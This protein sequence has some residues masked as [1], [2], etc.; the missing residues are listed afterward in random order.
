MHLLHSCFISPSSAAPLPLQCSTTPPPLQHHSPSTAAATAGVTAGLLFLLALLL[1]PVVSPHASPLL[2]PLVSL[3]ASLLLPLLLPLLVPLIAFPSATTA[4]ETI[5]HCG[6]LFCSHCCCHRWCHC[7][8]CLLLAIPSL[9]STSSS[10]QEAVTACSLLVSI[11]QP[12]L[13]AFSAPCLLHSMPS[14]LCAFSP[15]CLLSSVPSPLHA[16]SPPC[17]LSSVPSPLHAFSP[18]FLLLSV[19][20]LLH[21]ASSVGG[22]HSCVVLCSSAPLAFPPPCLF[23]RALFSIISFASPSSPLL[24]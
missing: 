7:W 18:P 15:P 2:P 3:V 21:A 23:L 19:A 22:N 8:P 5:C 11:S 12:C 14:L 6:P 20:S 1:P 13:C 10:T 4:A 16:F 17:L 24:L 9:H